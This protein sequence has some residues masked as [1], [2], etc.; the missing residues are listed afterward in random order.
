MHRVTQ[1]MTN[2]DKG[3]KNEEIMKLHN[4]TGKLMKENEKGFREPVAEVMRRYAVEPQRTSFYRNIE[5]IAYRQQT[6]I[7]TREIAR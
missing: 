7:A 4:V 5:G 6:G 2:Y 3:N 1:R